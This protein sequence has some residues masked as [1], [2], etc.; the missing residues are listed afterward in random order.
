MKH[1]SRFGSKNGRRFVA[2]ASVFAP[3]RLAVAVPIANRKSAIA[4]PPPPFHLRPPPFLSSPHITMSTPHPPHH[5]SP[6]TVGQLRST[7]Y[8]P[9]SVKDELRRNVI[10][11][12]KAGEE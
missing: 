4:N 7:E 2:F 9:S 1:S 3:S 10:R 11:K 5:P 6:A 12:L 8:R